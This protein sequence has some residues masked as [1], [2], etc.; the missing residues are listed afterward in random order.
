LQKNLHVSSFLIEEVIFHYSRM[1]T[2]Y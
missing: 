1:M 2:E